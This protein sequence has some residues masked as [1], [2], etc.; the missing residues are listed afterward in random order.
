MSSSGDPH[1]IEDELLAAEEYQAPPRDEEH[2]E[3][4]EPDRTSARRDAEHVDINLLEAQQERTDT[5]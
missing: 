4:F 2:V 5:K 1:A 3:G